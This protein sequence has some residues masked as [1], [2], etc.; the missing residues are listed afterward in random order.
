VAELVGIQWAYA[1]WKTAE[2]AVNFLLDVYKNIEDIKT[3][4]KIKK[5]KGHKVLKKLPKLV[6]KTDFSKF[7]LAL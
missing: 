2:D 6:A 3:K 1:Q 5:I 7:E 4:E